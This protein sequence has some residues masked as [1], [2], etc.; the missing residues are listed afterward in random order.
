MKYQGKNVEPPPENERLRLYSGEGT[1]TFNDMDFPCKYIIWQTIHGDIQGKLAEFH[2]DCISNLMLHELDFFEG[3]FK[4][5]TEK[6]NII[7]CTRIWKFGNSHHFSE[8][9]FD[10]LM[11]VGTTQMEVVNPNAVTDN[12]NGVYVTCGL[13]NIDLHRI[14]RGKSETSLGRIWFTKLPYHEEMISRAKISK[15]SIITGFA[16]IRNDSID[17]NSIQKYL[18]VLDKQIQRLCRVLSL[19]KTNHIDYTSLDIFLLYPD[20]DRMIMLK[21]IITEPKKRRPSFSRPLIEDLNNFYSFIEHG[22]LNYTDELDEI[23]NLDVA[24]EWYIGGTSANIIQ[25]DFLEL[26]VF[27]ETIKYRHAV[28]TNR[29]SVIDNPTKYASITE[30]MV[31][32]T[33]LTLIKHGYGGDEH[34]H[35]RSSFYNAIQ[36]MNRWPF[37]K[38]M[39]DLLLDLHLK[40]DDIGTS[41]SDIAKNRNLIV[42]CGIERPT[43]EPTDIAKIL[44]NTIAL[45]QRIILALLKYDGPFL[46]ILNHYHNA[47]FRDFIMPA[48]E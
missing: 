9:A 39:E 18:N 47:Q 2:D 41:L 30:E 45:S 24:F 32:A 36:G 1:I 31:Q 38:G 22:M 16:E 8:H 34:S 6:G 21:E 4:G 7:T 33:K 12:M 40:Y 37:Q 14:L 44:T 42:H 3:S 28:H 20:S 10:Y 29:T 17:E 46:N 5:I 25:M 23:Y 35:I 27:L 26:C 19:A 11:K 43:T 13:L 15:E 48:E